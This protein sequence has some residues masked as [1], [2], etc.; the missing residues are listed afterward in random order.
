[1]TKER[2][3]GTLGNVVD[4][5][6]RGTFL[7]NA[8]T[9]SS[10]RKS[11]WNFLLLLIFPLWLVVW[12]AVVEAVWLVHI[13]FSH[14]NGA[15]LAA[16]WMR[17]IG[18]GPMSLG[19]FLMIFAPMIPAMIAAMVIGNYLIYLI[20]AARHAM[21]AEDRNYPGTEY[22]TAQRQLGRLA[23]ITLPVALVVSFVGSMLLG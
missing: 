8:R 1:M 10:R 22:T 11:P 23:V 13:R 6:R 16:S 12:W 18:N 20:P 15:V 17:G 5:M 14:G 21:D 9:R 3:P 2:K 4:E 7:R 19:S